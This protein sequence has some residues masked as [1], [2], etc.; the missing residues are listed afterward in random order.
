MDLQKKEKK[1]ER[2]KEKR[3]NTGK[4][5]IINSCLV[6]SLR[7]CPALRVVQGSDAVWCAFS[8]SEKRNTETVPVN[9][10]VFSCELINVAGQ[11]SL[12]LCESLLVRDP[13]LSTYVSNIPCTSSLMLTPSGRRLSRCPL[14]RCPL[15]QSFARFSRLPEQVVS[16][17]GPQFTSDEFA[18]FMKSNGVKHIRTAPYSSVI[19]RTSRTICADRLWRLVARE[20]DE[21]SLSARLSVVAL[22]ALLLYSSTPHATTPSDYNGKCELNS[23]R[24]T[25][26]RPV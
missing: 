22:T 11:G 6:L 13:V 15:I 17:N 12:Y 26:T 21:P 19:K 8:S 25:Q 16:D 5:R 14:S 23:I 20:M 10:T 7:Y 9:S 3:D 18:Q 24:L 4:A 1:K 2:K